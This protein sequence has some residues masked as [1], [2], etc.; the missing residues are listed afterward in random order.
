MSSHTFIYVLPH[1]VGA[2]LMAGAAFRDRRATGKDGRA[3]APPIRWTPVSVVVLGSIAG[4]ALGGFAGTG[5]N[6]L[7]ILFNASW[8]G[9]V[10]V[11]LIRYLGRNPRAVPLSLL[12]LLLATVSCLFVVGNP[13]ARS[14]ADQVRTSGRV[15][16]EAQAAPSESPLPDV[17][18]RAAPQE[19]HRVHR[20]CADQGVV[21]G[22]ALPTH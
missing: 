11:G 22:D 12:S 4:S 7:L 6:A 18:A 20:P 19:R 5:P 3:E 10:L 15:C 1:I 8:S 9:L 14:E 2:A 16:L 17:P 13:A 21:T